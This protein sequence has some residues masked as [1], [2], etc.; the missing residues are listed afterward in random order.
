MTATSSPTQPE[1][2][3]CQILELNPTTTVTIRARHAKIYGGEPV[4][5]PVPTYGGAT[6]IDETTGDL[7]F[8]VW[9]TH[10]DEECV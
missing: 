3:L 1:S 8:D 5:L 4:I 6:L 10:G 9:P 7:L 2:M